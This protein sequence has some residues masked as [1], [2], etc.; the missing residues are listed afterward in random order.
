[1]FADHTCDKRSTRTYIANTF[2]DFV[3]ED[4][5]SEEDLLWPGNVE[6]GETAHDVA[7]R[8]K[9]V[10]DKIYNEDEATCKYTLTLLL[11]YPDD[12]A[13]HIDYGSWRNNQRI[14]GCARHEA[15]CVA[16]GRYVRKSG[17]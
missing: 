16:Y 9:K 13:R 7:V 17:Y 5:F 15:V 6:N 4:G 3:I 11:R 12:Q 10:L 8:A 2:P 1:M 14:S